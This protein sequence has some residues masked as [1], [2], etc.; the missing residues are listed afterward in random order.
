MS[1]GA[2]ALAIILAIVAVGGLIGLYAGSRQKMDLEQ[3]TVGGRG[4]GLA[5]V[6]LLMAGEI[7][8]TFTFMGASGWAYSKGGPALYIIAYQPLLYVVSFYVLPQVWEYGRKHRIQTIADFFQV[9]YASKHLA[10]FVALVGVAFLIPYLQ[11]QLT[12]LG[13]IVQIASF[14]AIGRTPAMVAAFALVAAFVHTSGVRGVAWVSVLK[15]I[16]MLSAVLMVGISIPII[17]FGGIGPMFAAVARAEPHHLLMPGSTKTL[18]HS[19]FVTTVMLTALGGYMW[20]TGFS[21]SLTAKSADTLRR[22]AVILPL[23]SITVPL[24]LFVGLSATLVLPHLRDGDLSMLTL[25][26]KTYPAWFL[27]FIG[28]AG[29]L[30]AMVP[31]A[32]LI[33]AAATLFAKNIYRP[34]FA[35]NIGDAE[36]AKLAKMMVL[37]ITALALGIA[38]YSSTSLVTLLLLGYSGVTQFFP[39]V[40]LGLYWKRVTTAGVFAGLIAGIATVAFLMLDDRN[41]LLRHERGVRRIVRQFRADRHHQPTKPRRGRRQPPRTHAG[42][43]FRPINCDFRR[44]SRLNGSK[45]DGLAVRAAPRYDTLRGIMTNTAASAKQTAEQSVAWVGAKVAAAPALAAALGA[46]RF[47]SAEALIAA[48]F[49]ADAIVLSPRD[50]LQAREWL[51]LLRQHRSLGLRPILLAASC[52]A[53]A[54]ALSD[55]VAANADEIGQYAAEIRERWEALGRSEPVDGDDQLLTFLY[56]HRNFRLEPVADWHNERVYYYPL[57]DICSR[58]REDGY[59][60]LARLQQRGLLTPE[61]LIERLHVCPDCG[62]AHL[63]FNE[64]CPHCAGID[65]ANQTF[66]HCYACGGVAPQDEYLRRDG[67]TC[68]KCSTRL[69]HIGVDY[70]RALETCACKTCGGRFT[71]PDIKARCAGCSKQFPTDSLIERRF[72]SLR[73]SSA[74]EAAARSGSVSDMLALIDEVSHAHPAY[75]AQTLDWLLGLSGRHREIC[76][77]V[78]ALRFSNLQALTAELPRARVMQKLDTLAQ[79]LRELLRGTDLFMRDDQQLCWLLLPQTNAA[80]LEILRSRIAALSDA[81]ALDESHRIEIEIESANSADLDDTTSSARMLMAQL[82]SE[83]A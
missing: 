79:H 10:A 64:L 42:H 71:E 77:S 51:T 39:G 46:M 56:L 62:S 17:Y 65:I 16:L 69:R 25:V 54:D 47:A 12:G 53:H 70:D 60:L 18:G 78:I 55:G 83:F 63:L 50:A 59:D 3:W 48:E 6:W 36:V 29:A 38:I 44:K 75:F 80:G 61:R 45:R 22:N 19:W 37:L 58:D 4:F 35:T 41:P 31:A 5:L 8:T 57:A 73:L 33:L 82:R 68:P 2:I 67:L 34:I 21:A 13:I 20:P 52:G 15:D 49:T 66:L 28:G 72:S 30:T 43:S 40:A 76:F 81:S 23:Y 24:I 74:G 1:G 7:Y 26:R 32:S 9:R 11:L 14:E 27:G